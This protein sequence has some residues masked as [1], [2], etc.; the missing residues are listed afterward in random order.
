MFEK[1]KKKV[2][3]YIHYNIAKA[4]D[5]F[6]NT[7]IDTNKKILTVLSNIERAKMLES[8]PPYRL[9]HYEY[10]SFSQHGEDGCI[11][12]IFNRIG[13][14]NKIFVEIGVE[15]GIENNTHLLL[16]TGWKGLWIEGSEKHC[17]EIR[18]NFSKKLNDGRLSLE[19]CFVRKDNIDDVIKK[20]FQG[21]IDLFS[22]DID[23]NDYYVLDKISS[24]HPRVVVTEYNASFFPPCR[25]VIQ[26][27]PEFVWQRDDYSGVSLQILVDWFTVR[28]YTLVGCELSGTNAFW[29]RNDLF[30]KEKFPYKTDPTELYHP[31]RM[32]SEGPKAH[33]AS[34]KWDSLE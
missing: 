28:G 13:T 34:S 7:N 14:T 25:M 27:D 21:E 12:E 29:V 9:E 30:T 2:R 18:K 16:E 17:Q 11:Y 15:S 32:Y 8:I 26:Y 23:G 24:I 33:P 5:G 3:E 4:L 20:Y 31:A 1:L 6:I 10:S 22:I 19:H